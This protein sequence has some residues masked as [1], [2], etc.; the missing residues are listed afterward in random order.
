VLVEPVVKETPPGC[1]LALDELS[2]LGFGHNPLL[3]GGG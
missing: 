1:I 3:C 2:E